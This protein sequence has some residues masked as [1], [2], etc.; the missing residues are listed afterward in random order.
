[1]QSD[2]SLI[3]NKLEKQTLNSD[4]ELTP[5]QKKALDIMTSGENVMITGMAGT[6]KSLLLKLFLTLSQANGNHVGLTSLTGISALVIGGSTLHSYLGIGL[7][8]AN[9]DILFSQIKSKKRIFDRWRNLDILI[10]D[11]VSMMTSELLEKLDSLAK[12]IRSSLLPFGGIQIILSGD[13]LQLPC[14]KE[15][16]S[17]EAEFCFESVIWSKLIKETVYL[18]DIIRQKD[19]EFQTCLNEVRLGTLSKKSKNLLLS[20]NNISF[21]SD[22][23]PTKIFSLNRQVDAINKKELERLIDKHSAVFEYNMIINVNPKDEM[24][25]KRSIKEIEDIKERIKRDSIVPEKLELT[26]D[27]QVMLVYNIDTENG[28]VNGSRGIVKEFTSDDLPIVE[29]M[30]GK[31]LTIPYQTWNLENDKIAIANYVQV[32]LKLAYAASIHKSQGLTLD[33]AEIDFTGIF[34]YGQAYVA[35]SRVKDLSGLRIRN[36]EEKRIKAHPKALEYYKLI[37]N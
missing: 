29:F 27:A 3:T 31:R 18:T 32:P 20:R 34:E 21:S 23:I 2:I 1:M 22:I 35:L 12:R 19:S 26:Y 8:K 9:V 5:S 36:F 6:G 15:G 30:N 28:L 4:I 37:N 17:S 7:G 11:E 14:I 16:G 10:I 25:N 13:F 24:G 33:C